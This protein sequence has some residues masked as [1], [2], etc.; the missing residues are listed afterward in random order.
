MHH[1]YGKAPMSQF[2]S[3]PAAVSGGGHTSKYIHLFG[4]GIRT[5]INPHKAHE[6]CFTR[7]FRWIKPAL[8]MPLTENLAVRR[9]WCTR[10]LLGR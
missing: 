2:H 8:F 7:V 10:C 6:V 3:I 9:A 5:R 4:D 1:A